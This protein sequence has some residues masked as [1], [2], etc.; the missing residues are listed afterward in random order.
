MVQPNGTLEHTTRVVLGRVPT[1]LGTYS[2]LGSQTP[3][4][5]RGVD[6]QGVRLHGVGPEGSHALHGLCVR[7]ACGALDGKVNP[8]PVRGSMVLSV[9]GCCPASLLPGGGGRRQVAGGR[10]ENRPLREWLARL[11]P[12]GAQLPR[13]AGLALLGRT[14]KGTQAPRVSPAQCGALRTGSSPPRGSPAS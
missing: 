13:T 12:L 8:N 9:D 11:R 4:C 10:C 5:V 1:P 7:C 3:V 6:K 14:A 2:S